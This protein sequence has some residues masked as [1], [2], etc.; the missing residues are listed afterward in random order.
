MGRANASDVAADRAVGF[1][2]L[3]DELAVF[4]R[5]DPATQTDTDGSH[6]CNV[7][8]LQTHASGSDSRWRS[9]HVRFPSGRSSRGVDASAAVEGESSPVV[10]ASV[11]ATVV[12]IIAEAHR[13]DWLGGDARWAS[14]QL[15]GIDMRWSFE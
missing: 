2:S 11:P 4:A 3:L 5:A 12:N 6:T 1:W 10:A 7:S 9:K 13:F 14:A 15:V 8:A